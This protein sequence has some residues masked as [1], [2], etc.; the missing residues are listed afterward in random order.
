VSQLLRF[1]ARSAWLVCLAASLAAGC[2]TRTVSSPFIIRKGHG[3]IEIE[4]PAMK[5]ISR[6]EVARAEREAIA[7]RAARPARVTPSIEQRDSG[8]RKAL[9]SLQ[10]EPSALAHVNV[11]V[12]YHRLRVLDAAFDQFS[13]AIA[14]DPRNAAAWDGRARLWRDWGLIV[15]ALA[16]AHRARYFAP[17]RAEVMNT[18]GT[19]LERAGQCDGARGAYRDALG[20]DEHAVWARQNLTRLETVGPDCRPRH[21]TA[22]PRAGH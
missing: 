8:L 20:L 22:S 6:E 15:P 19:I 13:Q 2:A 21:E 9:L 10:R 16:D 1:G 5:T 4:G 12:A 14:V 17:Q 3:P 11:G 18:L 7:A